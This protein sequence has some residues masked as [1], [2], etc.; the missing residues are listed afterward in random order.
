M[1]INFMYM[2]SQISSFSVDIIFYFSS[3]IVEEIHIGLVGTI[4]NKVEKTLGQYS[5]LMHILLFKGATYFGKEMILNKEH[6]GED[7][8]I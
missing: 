1:P 8:P 5:L 2:M 7:M 3:Y 4:K 6:E